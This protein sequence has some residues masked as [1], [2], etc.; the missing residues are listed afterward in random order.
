MSTPSHA[1]ATT[2]TSKKSGKKWWIIWWGIT[3][4]AA[5]AVAATLAMSGCEDQDPAGRFIYNE[6]AQSLH[7]INTSTSDAFL[8]GILEAVESPRANSTSDAMQAFDNLYKFITTNL[9][10]TGDDNNVRCI[11]SY[12]DVNGKPSFVKYAFSAVE[13]DGYEIVSIRYIG[14]NI[15]DTQW[16]PMRINE[17]IVI[18]KSKTSDT[19]YE[20]DPNGPKNSRVKLDGDDIVKIIKNAV[21]F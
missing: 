17:N 13:E 14:T 6:D 20:T 4:L 15:V 1:P 10:W 12:D 5:W 9:K 7:D 8:A 2:P 11:Y 21:P 19:V 18:R 3:T 16:N